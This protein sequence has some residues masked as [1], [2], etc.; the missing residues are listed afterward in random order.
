MAALFSKKDVRQA[1]GEKSLWTR[2]KDVALM[3][4]AV[5]VKG[6][7]TTSI[8]SIEE[9]LLESDFGVGPTLQVVETMTTEGKKGQAENRG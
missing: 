1:R 7:D 2:I 8:E 5:M 4:V 3:D 9:L 6:L